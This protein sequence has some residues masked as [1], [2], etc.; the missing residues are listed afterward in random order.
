[1]FPE[2]GAV[3]ARILVYPC[4]RTSPTACCGHAPG[5]PHIWGHPIQAGRTVADGGVLHWEVIEVSSIALEP[6]ELE[7]AEMEASTRTVH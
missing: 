1:M 2:Y 7:L 4:A 3:D 6:E 5:S